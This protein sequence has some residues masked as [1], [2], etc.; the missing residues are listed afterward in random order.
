[1][2]DSIV[3]AAAGAVSGAISKTMM[4]PLERLKLVVQL[5]GEIIQPSM[6]SSSTAASTAST[7]SKVSSSS[8]S[9]SSSLYDG[10][11]VALRHMI[12]Q[13]GFLA[14]W[15]GNLPMILIQGG[16][17]A[18][19][20]VFMD[21]WKKSLFLR[22]NRSDMTEQDYTPSAAQRSF[23]SAALGGATSMTLLYPLGLI[24]TKLAL[25][26][27]RG[28]SERKYRGMR[29]VVVDSVRTNG[30]T[31]LFQGYGVALISV[32][33]YRMIH[34]GGY[35]VVKRELSVRKQ[36]DFHPEKSTANKSDENIGDGGGDLSWWERLG[37]AQVVS[38]TASTVHY[39]L[40]SVRRRLMMQSDVKVKRYT[41]PVD[42]VRK[43][44]YN[45]GIT[46]FYRGLGTSYIRSVGAAALLISYDFFKSLMTMSTP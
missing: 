45:E 25:D 46:G 34:L 14:L 37:A 16:S 22:G 9:S 39:P 18:L 27:G 8:S 42:C 4:A 33:V 17:S 44:Y 35:E 40:D 28:L 19:N 36:Q 32:T 23:A 2:K 11:V 7:A 26:M 41:S 10:P 3:E 31:S 13:E 15:R 38:M 1:M 6:P 21:L 43:I 24:R 5:R 12:R 20:F 30:I 29:D